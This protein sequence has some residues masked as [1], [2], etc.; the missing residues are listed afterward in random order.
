MRKINLDILI[1]NYEVI[2]IDQWGVIH[3]GLV[4]LNAVD[5]FINLLKRKG[6]KIILISNSSQT[7][8]SIINETLVPLGF[9]PEMFYKIISSGEIIK[10]IIFSDIYKNNIIK[11]IITKKECIIISNQSDYKNAKIFDL[12]ES[13]KKNAR[14]I[15]AMSLDPTFSK[16]KIKTI[17]N[18]LAKYKIPMICTNP[19]KK[20]YDG[21]IGKICFQVGELAN[22]FSRL[23]GETIYVGKPEKIMFEHSLTNIKKKDY[24][25]CIMIGDSLETDIEGGNRFNIDTLLILDGIHKNEFNL[26][27][28]DETKKNIQNK[29]SIL[30]KFYAKNIESIMASF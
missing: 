2:L 27:T 7:K 18:K 3:N 21:N 23:D 22:Q 16:S 14:F 29:Y 5:Q 17:A 12:I 13:N 30:P 26:R 15:F 24:K 8:K 9:R 11:K 4:K 19:D 10:K 1:N 20:V 6:K 28:I 25:K